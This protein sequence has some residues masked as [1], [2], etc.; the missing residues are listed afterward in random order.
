MGLYPEKEIA[1]SIRSF[2]KWN[3]ILHLP[4]NNPIFPTQRKLFS[5]ALTRA[6]GIVAFIIGSTVLIQSVLTN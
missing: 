5:V 6:F 2:R 4:E 1:G 3:E